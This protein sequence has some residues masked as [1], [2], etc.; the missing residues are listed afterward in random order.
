MRRDRAQN[1]DIGIEYVI[2]DVL[3]GILE[4]RAWLLYLLIVC[5]RLVFAFSLRFL[6]LLIL[7]VFV[8][9]T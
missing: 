8:N 9:A 5:I 6:R 3:E 2:I 1:A 4:A 7:E